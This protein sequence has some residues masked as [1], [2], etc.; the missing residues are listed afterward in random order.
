MNSPQ[1]FTHF[2]LEE[3]NQGLPH[4]RETSKDSG[5]LDAIVIRPKENERVSLDECELSP[6]GGVHGDGWAKKEGGR[7]EP[8]IQV[9]LMNARAISIIAGSKERWPLA[10]D[11]LYVDFDLSEDNLPPGQSLAIGGCVLEVTDQPHTGCTKFAERYGQDALRFVNSDEGKRMHLRG[12]YAKIVQA[13]TI[14]V[15]DTVK[16]I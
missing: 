1:K 11:Q 10:G 15:G 8:R 16:K 14:S 12:I 3:L 4:I 6:E 9:T 7:P 13:G 5:T 2:S